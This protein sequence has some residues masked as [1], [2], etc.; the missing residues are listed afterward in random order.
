[1]NNA[2][3]E[4]VESSSE[5][6]LGKKCYDYL[7]T[8]HCN[9][10]K[11]TLHQAMS[12]GKNVTDE[13]VARPNGKE[14]S[15]MYTGSPVYNRDNELTGALEFIAD[16]S[17]IKNMQDYLSRSTQRL[18]SGMN[19]FAGGDL[20]TRVTPERT[21]DDIEKLF[22]AFNEVVEKFNTTI[23]TLVDAVEATASAS[24]QNI[25]KC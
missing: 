17:D 3:L 7:K 4:L 5:N 10:E 2:G 20:S 14:Y 1:M 22:V 13:T 21:G 24:T 11:C 18:L 25:F 9:T 15:I 6:V 23:L 19:Q 12:K 8:D 16:I